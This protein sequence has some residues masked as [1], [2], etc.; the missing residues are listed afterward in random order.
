MYYS[1]SAIERSLCRPA[2]MAPGKAV[3]EDLAWT[4]LRMLPLYPIDE[5]AALCC[6][7]I[8]KIH[9]IS[10]LYSRT[11]Y[12]TRSRS[13]KKRGRIRAMMATQVDVRDYMVCSV[14]FLMIFSSFYM[15]LF[16]GAAISFW[17]SFKSS[18]Y[19]FAGL[20]CH[21]QQYGGH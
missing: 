9:D 4:I 11:G 14:M 16:N 17:M 6:V 13:D 7:S 15:A 21:G 19:R 12:V 5:I 1:T 10:A 2:S 20:V 8:W 3:S 18:F